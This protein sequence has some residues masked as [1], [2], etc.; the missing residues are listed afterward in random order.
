MCNSSIKCTEIESRYCFNILLMINYFPVFQQLQMT[1]ELPKIVENY[2]K[3][4]SF[5][6]KILRES[7]P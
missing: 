3:I 1:F 7:I 6:E 2:N 4:D 5:H